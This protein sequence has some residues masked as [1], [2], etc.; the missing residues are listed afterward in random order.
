MINSHIHM[1][2]DTVTDAASRSITFGHLSTCQVAVC[3]VRL[4]AHLL[5][6]DESPIYNIAVMVLLVFLGP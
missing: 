2:A 1:F 3:A 6:L 4:P 5:E